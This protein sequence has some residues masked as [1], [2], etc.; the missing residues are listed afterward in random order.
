MKAAF[1]EKY[2]PPDVVMIKELPIPQIGENELLIRVHASTLDSA[3]V[4]IR[5][6]SAGF[7]ISLIMRFVMGF[8]RPRQPILGHCYSGIVEKVGS[9]CK[10]F[11]VGD[12][13]FGTSEG[14]NFGAHAEYIK[15]KEDSPISSI[16]KDATHEEAA[17]L[18]FGGTVALYFL[19]KAGYQSGQSILILGG[20]G[21]VGS[22][23]IQLAAR[24][25][26]S[27]HTV[28]SGKNEGVLLQLGAEEVFDRKS[29]WAQQAKVYD[30]VFDAIGKFDKKKMRGLLKPGGAFITVA[31]SDV[32]KETKAQVQELR[33]AFEEGS[34][35]CVIDS[36]FSLDEIQVAHAYVDEGKKLGAVVVV[37][38]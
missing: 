16:P 23:A 27:V 7:P 17:A 35:L 6:L 37:M 19:E 4:R 36:T 21:A 30:I 15:V 26:L 24:K 33:S 31:S 2:G 34:L 3:D 12:R 28:S 10:E 8:R 20:S 13:V 38:S 25:G 32:A 5:A 29:A 18:L 11:A 22:S 14:M 1:V 9:A